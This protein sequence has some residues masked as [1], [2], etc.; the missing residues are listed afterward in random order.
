MP[1]LAKTKSEVIS[2]FR[3]AEILDAAR[4]VFSRKNFEQTTVDDIAAAAHVAK[5]TLYL[6]Y[7][8]KREIYLEALRR[9]IMALSEE[10]DRRMQGCNTAAEKI[11]AFISTRVKFFEENRGFFRIYYSEFAHF[12]VP[13]APAPKGLREL[14]IRQAK[15]LEAILQ[16]AVEK[17]EIRGICPRSTA[18]RLYDMTLGVIAQRLLGW[19]KA[20]VEE[21]IEAL[22]E[23]LWRGID[24]EH[25]I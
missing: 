3:C 17:R 22:F 24:K 12:Y 8:S 7:K 20:P 6:Y 16:Q 4:K 2:E 13:L 21:D 23:L 10:T 19:S 15:R 1:V 18:L 11:R 14:Y 5:G 25:E 9:D